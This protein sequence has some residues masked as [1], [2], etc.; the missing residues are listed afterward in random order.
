[1]TMRKL[2]ICLIA[3]AIAFSL[4]GLAFRSV[5]A[6]NGRIGQMPAQH[7]EQAPVYGTR[8]VHDVELY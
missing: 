6:A 7:A 4:C 3:F 1:M 2:T 5:I 8:A